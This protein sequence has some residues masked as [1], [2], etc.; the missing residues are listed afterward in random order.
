[1]EGRNGALGGVKGSWSYG[2]TYT[3]EPSSVLPSRLPPPPHHRLIARHR[4]RTSSA[5]RRL[6]DFWII[7]KRQQELAP[8]QLEETS[9]DQNR[10]KSDYL[11]LQVCA[12]QVY[13]IKVRRGAKITETLHLKGQLREDDGRPPPPSFTASPAIPGQ[14]RMGKRPRA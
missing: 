8:M 14:N 4:S 3:R 13:E 5:C 12:Q 9:W 10:E 11:K 7:T 1:M 2:L 6:H